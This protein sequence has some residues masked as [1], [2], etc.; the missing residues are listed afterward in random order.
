VSKAIFRLED[1]MFRS[2]RKPEV[3]VA[4]LAAAG[5]L[6][7]TMGARQSLGL[8]VGPLNTSTGLGIGTISLALAVG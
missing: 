6:L 2:L 4:T 7:I 8:F 5:I 3:L 1:T